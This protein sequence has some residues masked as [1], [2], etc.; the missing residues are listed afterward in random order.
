MTR[1]PV[2]G[3][4][5]VANQLDNNLV[6]ISTAGAMVAVRAANPA[7]VSATGANSALFGVA[8]TKDAAGNLVVYF[9]DDTDDTVKKLTR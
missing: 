2:N 6:E 4:L 3:D 7:M 9:V 1:N 8:A 5:I